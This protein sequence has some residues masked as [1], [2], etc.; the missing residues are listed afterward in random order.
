[1]IEFNSLPTDLDALVKKK[2]KNNIV[3]VMTAQPYFFRAS[4]KF[5]N[6]LVNT[7]GRTENLHTDRSRLAD[8]RHH[9]I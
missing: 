4:G 7:S 2:K 6:I 8:S 3:S 5:P 9:N 1:M